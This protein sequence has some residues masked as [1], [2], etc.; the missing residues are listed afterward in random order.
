MNI[1]LAITINRP[2]SDVFTFLSDK[3]RYPQE[4]GSPVLLLEKTTPGPTGVGTCYRE[5]VQMFPFYKGE[6]LSEITHFDPNK[7]LEEDF[8]GPGMHGHL[9]YYFLSNG[10]GTDLIQRETFHFHGLLKMFEPITGSILYRRL[11]ERLEEIKVILESGFIF[12]D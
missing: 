11:Q 5:V 12:T 4:Q 8:R 10:D 3:D 9:A 2:P 7:R 1:E 6:I